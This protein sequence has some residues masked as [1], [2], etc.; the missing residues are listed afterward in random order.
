[1]VQDHVIHFY[2][3]HALDWVDVTSALK[4]DPVKTSSIAQ[5]ISNYEKSSATYFRGVQARVKGVVESGQLSL[6]ASGYWGHP[7]YTLRPGVPIASYLSGGVFMTGIKHILFP[8]DFSER[9]C[10]AAPFVEAMASRA[11]K[12]RSR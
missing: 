2:H 7:A 8:I 1:M 5:S 10:A 9:C 12:R 6:F 3:L 11:T 4:A